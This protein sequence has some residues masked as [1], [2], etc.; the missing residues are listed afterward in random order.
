MNKVIHFCTLGILLLASSFASAGLVKN[1]VLTIDGVNRS[2]DVFIPDGHA[3]SP[4]PLVFLLHGHFGDADVMTGQNN[5][6][7]PYKV[8]LSIAQ[9]EGWYLVIPDGE[10]GADNQRGWNDCRKEAGTNPRTDDVKF[11]NSLLNKVS[12]QYAINRNRIYAHGTSN[13]GHMAYR[14]AQESGNR[15]RA[16]AAIVASMPENN[17]CR[18]PNHPISV[19]VMNG[20]KDPLLPYQGGKIGRRNADK[21][22]RG[23]VTST[24]GTIRYWLRTN[25]ISSRPVERALPNINRRDRSSVHVSRYT[26]GRNNT[27]VVLYKVLGGGHTEPSLTQHY[28]RL[29]K[30]IV[31]Q[32]NRD[33][34]MA[35]EVWKFFNRHR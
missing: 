21:H 22:G 6:R 14:L 11:L 5:K 26:G 27:E 3:Y 23:A 25:G 17:K 16:I 32:Q 12:S 35:E 7:A 34:E 31:G 4:R 28:R 30:L 29:Y 10:R 1:Q 2:Y 9:R 8:W 13:G 20:T 24:D 33:I 19:L 15:Y 18:K